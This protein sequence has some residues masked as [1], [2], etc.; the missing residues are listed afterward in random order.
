[1]DNKIV[2][3]LGKQATF[4]YICFLL[5]SVTLIIRDYLALDEFF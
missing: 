1:M 2:W 5:A 4:C 3:Q